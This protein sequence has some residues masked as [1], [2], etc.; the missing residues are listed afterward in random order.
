MLYRRNGVRSKRITEEEG[1]H[2]R[3]GLFTTANGLSLSSDV[4]EE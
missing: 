1:T 3:L 2:G 4:S